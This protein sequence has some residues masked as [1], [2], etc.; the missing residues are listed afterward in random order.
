MPSSRYSTWL[1][2]STFNTGVLRGLIWVAVVQWVLKLIIALG[3][4]V[5]ATWIVC[6]IVKAVF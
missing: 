2:S 3:F 6:L 4:L 1:K 5:L